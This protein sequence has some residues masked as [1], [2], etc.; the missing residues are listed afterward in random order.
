MSDKKLPRIAIRRNDD[1]SLDDI[2]IKDVDMVHIEQMN[3]QDWWIGI[4]LENGDRI[5]FDIHSLGKA[6]VKC[7]M[8]EEPEFGYRDLDS[9]PK[10]EW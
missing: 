4:S 1:D 9:L 5:C 8:T 10:S 3:D 6:H 2:V 7:T